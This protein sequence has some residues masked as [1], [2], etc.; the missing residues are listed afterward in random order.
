MN[1]AIM[2]VVVVFAIAAIAASLFLFTGNVINV[3]NNG[4]P[5]YATK[6]TIIAEAYQ[7]AVDNPE[8]LNGINCYC[9]CMQH[10]HDGRLHKR[11][12]LDCFMKEDGSFEQHASDC[13][14]CI[15]DALKVKS[16]T[17]QG[18]PK[19]QINAQISAQYVR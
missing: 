1:S 9:G 19:E 10:L 8:A 5:Y 3:N 16:L 15:K 18:I 17:A 6:N 12:L 13:D 11:G 2:A 14:M 7:F 4:L